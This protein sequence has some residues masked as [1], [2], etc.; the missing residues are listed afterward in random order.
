MAELEESIGEYIKENGFSLT[1][2]KLVYSALGAAIGTATG[3]LI[4]FKIAYKKAEKKYEE[5]A[6]NE[7]SDI[8]DH[9]TS[10]LNAA[11]GRV[12]KPDVEELVTSLKYT[13]ERPSIHVDEFTLP[14]ED[15]EEEKD[16]TEE[17]GVVYNIFEE[18]EKET[19]ND[20]WD[21][22]VEVKNRKA[23]VP[24]VIHVDEFTSDE[25]DFEKVSL[26]YYAEDDVVADVRDNVIEDQELVVG[27]DNLNKFGHGSSNPNVV[28]VRNEYLKQ[29]MEITYNDSS[30][31]EQVHGFKHSDKIRR[32]R[33]D[34]DG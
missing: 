34:W 32:G 31:A 15:Q 6:D 7:I 8:R 20:S 12:N 4:A 33:L 21:Y 30:F 14:S 18:T 11:M 23:T 22:A 28:F 3:A 13:S 10:K 19:T 26:I 1:Q 27:I 2:V 16:I 9:Y 29:D 24:Y 5:L 25:S 17:A